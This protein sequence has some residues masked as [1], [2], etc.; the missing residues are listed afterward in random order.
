MKGLP[1]LKKQVLITLI[2]AV[3]VSIASIIHGI[4]FDLKWTEI[5]RLTLKGFIFTL[6]V[7]FPTLLILERI[8]DLNNEK[9]FEE[10]EKRIKKLEKKR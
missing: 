3:L 6:I 2:F 4:F 9:K 10:I 1:L 5:E 7:I 8:F